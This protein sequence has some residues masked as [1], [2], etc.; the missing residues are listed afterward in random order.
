[1]PFIMPSGRIIPDIAQ[2]GNATIVL[3]VPID[4][5]NSATFSVRYGQRPIERMSRVRETGFDD[6][7]FYSEDDCKFRFTRN[8]FAKQKRAAMDAS[9]SGFRGIALED[10]VIV[11][12]MGA[13]YDRSLEH[14]VAADVAVVHFRRRLFEQAD[15]VERGEAPIGVNIDHR[16]VT[17][18]DAPMP[19]TGHWRTLVPTHV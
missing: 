5:E 12:S 17:A 7:E 6:P 1:V 9:W 8:D 2:T 16:C 3:E 15:R 19:E 18:I 14:L 4:D 10:A 13:I 11:T